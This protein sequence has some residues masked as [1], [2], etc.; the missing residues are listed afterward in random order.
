[1]YINLNDPIDTKLEDLSF[2]PHTGI[3]YTIHAS[4]LVFLR[5]YGPA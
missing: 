2:T 4:F 5:T 1:M 3:H